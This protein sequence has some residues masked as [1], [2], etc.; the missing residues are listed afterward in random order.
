MLWQDLEKY[1][2]VARF[3]SILF[4]GQ[5][6]REDEGYNLFRPMASP[7]Y[8][9]TGLDFLKLSAHYNGGSI[10]VNMVH[11]PTWESFGEDWED[12][13]DI[14]LV[15]EPFGLFGDASEVVCNGIRCALGDSP[16]SEYCTDIIFI[17]MTFNGPTIDGDRIVLF[18]PM[19]TMGILVRPNLTL[20]ERLQT[21]PRPETYGPIREWRRRA[22]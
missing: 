22:E 2:E 5:F 12:E 18:D 3:Q 14:G 4:E 19:S 20:E 8:L 1:L 9:S 6:I 10:D 17:E 15:D 11:E 7:V 13:E 21:H 16:D